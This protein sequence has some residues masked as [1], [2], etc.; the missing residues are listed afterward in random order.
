[1]PASEPF[2]AH[3]RTLRTNT[4]PSAVLTIDVSN[5]PDCVR[6]TVTGELDL[7]T[8]PEFDRQLDRIDLT[9]VKRLVLDVSGVPFMDSTGLHAVVQRHRSVQANGCQ[10]IV[11][12]GPDQVQR[13]FELTGVEDVLTF[14]DEPPTHPE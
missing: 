6:V 1:M 7:A 5:G 3:D 4:G 8:V 13:L 10:L 2:S 9:A 14:E 12:R 11:R